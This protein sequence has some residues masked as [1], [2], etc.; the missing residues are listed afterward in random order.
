MQY[1]ETNTS[2]TVFLDGKPEL[3]NNTH[4]NFSKIVDAVHANDEASFDALFNI[5]KTV[6]KFVSPT[7]LIHVE[8][9]VVYYTGEGAREEIN[10]T[11]VDRILEAIRV[12][13]S[14][15]HLLKFLENLYTNPS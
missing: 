7:G 8:N 5:A 15:T 4:P 11:L 2:I 12:G 3:V 14:P 9:G 1:I 13:R 6:E 10:G